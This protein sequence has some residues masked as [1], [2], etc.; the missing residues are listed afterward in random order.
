[1]VDTLG[2]IPGDFLN[3]EF[4]M[5][6]PFQLGVQKYIDLLDNIYFESKL[7]NF[8]RM[9]KWLFDSPDQAGEAYRLFMKD[10]SQGNKLIQ[11]QVEIGNKRVD[12]GNIRIPILNIYA[13]QD[14]LLQHL[15]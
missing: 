8:L 4:L 15:P 13:E 14:P 12:L 7:I 10:F 9:E 11:G 1:M 5:L 6:K 3:W 2:N